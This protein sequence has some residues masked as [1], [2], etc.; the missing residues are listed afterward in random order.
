MVN[1]AHALMPAVTWV[2]RA[3]FGHEL[4]AAQP[5]LPIGHCKSRPGASVGPRSAT[6]VGA[7]HRPIFA[8][9]SARHSTAPSLPFS[10]ATSLTATL[11]AL[12]L[13]DG[14]DLGVIVLILIPW[15]RLAPT[16]HGIQGK[17]RATMDEDGYFWF[18]S[19]SGR[20]IPALRPRE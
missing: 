7:L 13:V 9:A 5:T 18:I 4:L 3:V 12:P 6:A 15:G 14:I 2:V 11:T 19:K 8:L 17:L 20:A 1:G 10:P 16:I